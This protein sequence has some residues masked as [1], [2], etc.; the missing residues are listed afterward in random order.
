MQSNSDEQSSHELTPL[1]QPSTSLSITPAVVTP[2]E[3]EDREGQVN[4]NLPGNSGSHPIKSAGS[5]D[6]RTVGFDGTAGRWGLGKAGAS[7]CEFSEMVKF[8]TLDN[9]GPTVRTADGKDVK[10]AGQVPVMLNAIQLWSGTHRLDGNDVDLPASA[11]YY[12]TQLVRRQ[13]LEN[14][15]FDVIAFPVMSAFEHRPVGDHKI[16]IFNES[17]NILLLEKDLTFKGDLAD[18]FYNAEYFFHVS[19]SV[20]LNEVVRLELIAQ[21]ALS[22]A[23]SPIQSVVGGS[24]SGAGFF[25]YA[26]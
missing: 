17:R 19:D 22:N 6:L 9:S 23:N 20:A 7:R 18:L 2:I 4:Y 3:S 10:I 15:K 13:H 5:F 25:D 12:V 8:R 1:Q 21:I 14:S 11:Q 24:Y 16:R 26:K